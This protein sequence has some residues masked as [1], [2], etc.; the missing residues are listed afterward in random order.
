MFAQKYYS[1]DWPEKLFW[2]KAFQ[3]QTVLFVV[4]QTKGNGRN[5]VRWN[6]LKPVF[7][8]SATQTKC[9]HKEGTQA[10]L[11]ATAGLTLQ[12]KDAGTLLGSHVFAPEATATPTRIKL[13]KQTTLTSAET[14]TL[15]VFLSSSTYKI[16]VE[17][18][19]QQVYTFQIQ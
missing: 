11:A 10:L 14:M 1:N 17:R 6:W 7:S 5:W 2:L 18:Y 8:V 4:L 12:H 3:S 19:I 16:Y 9:C 13:Q 15:T